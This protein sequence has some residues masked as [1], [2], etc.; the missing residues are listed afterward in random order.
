MG[1]RDV[2]EEKSEKGKDNDRDELHPLRRGSKN[3]N[4]RDDCEGGLE[5]AENILR[6]PEYVVGIRQAVHPLQQKEPRSPDKRTD[7][8]G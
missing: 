3:Q 8:M 5:S 1:K 7:G 4:R 2:D 6:N